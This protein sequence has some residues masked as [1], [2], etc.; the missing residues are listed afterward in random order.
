MLSGRVSAVCLRIV[1]EFQYTFPQIWT[2]SEIL[3]ARCQKRVGQVAVLTA[4][5]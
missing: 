1:G 2:F 5:R 3:R 4:G